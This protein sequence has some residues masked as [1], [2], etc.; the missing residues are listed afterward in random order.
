MKKCRLMHV[1]MLSTTIIS[2]EANATEYRDC[3]PDVCS[4]SSYMSCNKCKY[5]EDNQV[6]VAGYFEEGSDM[7]FYPMEYRKYD[8][9]KL[10]ESYTRDDEA[11]HATQYLYNDAGQLIQEN[12]KYAFYDDNFINFS[13]FDYTDYTYSGISGNESTYSYNYDNAGHLIEEYSD[14]QLAAKYI[15]EDG[16]LAAKASDD[17][18]LTTYDSAGNE[19]SKNY[20]GNRSGGCEDRDDRFESSCRQI[21]GN[22]KTLICVGEESCETYYI[23]DENGNLSECN[24]YVNALLGITIEDEQRANAPQSQRFELSD[25]S[26]KI[27]DADGK[28]HYEGKRIYT[29]EEA[30]QVAGKVNRV[31]IRYR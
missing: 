9:G 18:Y 20:I 12:T 27:I 13:V 29:I 25:G 15:Y 5:N 17:G 11:F 7:G 3:P 14:G 2:F 4:K 30:N 10:I 31:S 23:E 22:G 6:T 16:H 28:V 21:L 8:N 24:G 26:T 1:L 19:V